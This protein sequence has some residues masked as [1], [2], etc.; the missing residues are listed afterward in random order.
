MI[1]IS[2]KIQTILFLHKKYVDNIDYVVHF[3]ISTAELFHS[4]TSVI[5]EL[6]HLLHM[7]NTKKLNLTKNY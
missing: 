2:E 6:T 3:M 5:K 1:Q 7:S 4:A